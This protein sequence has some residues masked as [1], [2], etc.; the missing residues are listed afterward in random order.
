MLHTMSDRTTSF[1]T[2]SLTIRTDEGHENVLIEMHPDLAREVET[3]AQSDR[4][5]PDSFLKQLL[6]G[7]R[8]SGQRLVD[9][10]SIERLLAER[11]E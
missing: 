2:R 3:A 6:E 7:Y 9:H 11:D 4:T 1:Q 5:S 10:Q 8:L